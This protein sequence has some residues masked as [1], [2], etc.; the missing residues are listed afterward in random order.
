MSGDVCQRVGAL[1][2]RYNLSGSRL[3]VAVSGGP[4][5]VCLLH[6]LATLKKELRLDLHVAH[7]NHMLRGEESYA[8][9]EYVSVLACQ[10]GLTVDIGK[11]DVHSLR[12]KHKMTLEEA[13]R[14]ARY[15]FLVQVACKYNTDLIV[16]G[17]TQND[18]TETLLLHIIRG[19]GIQGLVGLRPVTPRVIENQQVKIIRPMLDITRCET[20]DYCCVHK[21]SPRLDSS[22]LD[23]APMRNKI[24]MQLLP[25]L[26]TY[27]DGIAAT[28][29]RL[30]SVASDEVAY[31]DDQVSHLACH[32]TTRKGD[33]ITLNKQSLTDI[34][35]VLLRHLLRGCLEQ[36]PNGL[37]NI[38]SVHIENMLALMKK[39]AGRQMSLPHGLLF[40]NGYDCYWLGRE[41][42]LP[43]QFPHLENNHN[44]LIPGVTSLHGWLVE[45]AI[46]HAVGGYNDP[47]VAYMDMDAAGISLCVRSWQEGDCF[48]PLGLG[49]TKKLG[50]F[51]IDARI[52]R[53][54]RKGIPVVA[55]PAGV[56][57]LVGYRLDNRVKVTEKTQRILRLEFHRV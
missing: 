35:P 53:L 18:Q 9:A 48:Q 16:V 52:P 13:A 46:V 32:A 8:D 39:P 12:R 17:H 44:L 37:H 38:E 23:L 47:M 20:H 29:L 2:R 40:L 7:L 42:D 54:W 11:D 3:L 49:G 22:N 19:C 36:L 34:P 45:A 14:D 1:L 56:I 15:R 41:T 6:V 21:L 43:C 24:R 51:M 33:V 10:M 5:S 28:L 31:L 4:D 27:N 25:L 57:W 50:K 55:A 30:S 26:E